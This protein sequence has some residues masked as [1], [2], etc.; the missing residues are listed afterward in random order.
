MNVTE[1]VLVSACLLGDPVRYDGKPAS[2]GHNLLTL[3]QAENRLVKLCPEIEGGLHV[4]RAPAEIYQGDGYAV[5]QGKA[6]VIT[7][8]HRDVSPAFIRGAQV[9]LKLARQHN[10][11]LALLKAKSPSCGN[12]EI[13][14]GQ[15]NST[16]QTGM[17]VTAALLSQH[18][19]KV[20]NETQIN[21][22]AQ[23]L[24]TPKII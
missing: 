7:K 15:F 20:Y 22:L 21:E 23:A 10:I 11:K 2:T 5:I 4:P 18:G 8:S 12:H 1:K 24:T 6:T 17:G 16:L 19:I 14:N 3:W 9:A 13:Y